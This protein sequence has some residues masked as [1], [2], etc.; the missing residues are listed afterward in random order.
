MLPWATRVR[1]ARLSLVKPTKTCLAAE[2][3]VTLHTI[4]NWETGVYAPRQ[5]YRNKIKELCLGGETVPGVGLDFLLGGFDANERVLTRP[6]FTRNK[7]ATTLSLVAIACKLSAYVYANINITKTPIVIS[8]DTVFNTYPSC[9][10]I[11]VSPVNVSRVFYTITLSH[12]PAGTK[13]TI[14]LASTDGNL[15]QGL[16]VAEVSDTCLHTIVRLLKKSIN[17]LK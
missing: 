9:V 4:M 7:N 13:Y 16:C 10:R 8:M 5:Q 6:L 1:M 14:K 2:L 3:Q 11:L 15:L 17:K 12:R